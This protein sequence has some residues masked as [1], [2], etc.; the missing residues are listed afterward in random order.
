MSS[1]HYKRPKEEDHGSSIDKVAPETKKAKT[2]SKEEE[3]FAWFKQFYVTRHMFS[4]NPKLFDQFDG[5]GT[6][7]SRLSLY[8]VFVQRVKTEHDAWKLRNDKCMVRRVKLVAESKATGAPLSLDDQKESEPPSVPLSQWT[9]LFWDH[10]MRQLLASRG[11]VTASFEGG[12]SNETFM[13]IS[14]AYPE[15]PSLTDQLDGDKDRVSHLIDLEKEPIRP[16]TAP[17]GML[18]SGIVTKK[19]ATWLSDED[20]DKCALAHGSKATTREKKLRDIIIEQIKMCR[21][22]VD[23][24][25]P[26][27]SVNDSS[28]ASVIRSILENNRKAL[29]IRT[30]MEERPDEMDRKPID[31]TSLIQS[32]CTVVKCVQCDERNVCLTD[33]TKDKV[34]KERVTSRFCETCFQLPVGWRSL[35][36]A[37]DE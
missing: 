27:S 3:A 19:G 6:Y 35:L 9:W 31:I 4:K 12:W 18:L 5:H 23:K 10:A 32:G 29:G 33:A 28:D 8:D 34:E 24:R 37:D 14:K 2:Q 25:M 11:H 17:I 30:L 36:T 26:L 13:H 15:D 21:E 22:F 1:A 16:D 20:L 7:Q